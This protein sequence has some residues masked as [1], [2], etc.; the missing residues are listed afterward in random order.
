MSTI[1]EII[2]NGNRMGSY[3]AAS[4]SEAVD[5]F[6]RDAGYSSH[7][8]LL[9]RVPGASR[10]QL[11]ITEQTAPVRL[12]AGLVEWVAEGLHTAGVQEPGDL[13]ATI[14][15]ALEAC[16]RVV[17]DEG[18]ELEDAPEW[19]FEAVCNALKA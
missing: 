14:I 12:T 1:Y 11:V 13:E 4:E 10:D 19:L 9:E 16:G 5:A 3:R 8:D 17:A 15:E 6:A 18:D 7:A 2:A